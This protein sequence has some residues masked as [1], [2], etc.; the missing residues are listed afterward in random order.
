MHSEGFWS[1]VWLWVDLCAEFCDQVKKTQRKTTQQKKGIIFRSK[2][3]DSEVKVLIQNL[4]YQPASRWRLLLKSLSLASSDPL[5]LHLSK[6]PGCKL[7]SCSYLHL[8]PTGREANNKVDKNLLAI[9]NLSTLKIKSGNRW[10]CWSVWFFRCVEFSKQ[11][12]RKGL[13]NITLFMCGLV[14][15]SFSFQQP[16]RCYFL[17]SKAGPAALKRKKA[18]KAEMAFQFTLKGWHHWHHSPEILQ[19]TF[20]CCTNLDIFTS[21]LEIYS[22]EWLM[23][24]G[25]YPE[26]LQSTFKCF[27]SL[28]I[29]TFIL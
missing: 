2:S 24:G 15:T 28:D 29:F 11:T 19:L 27:T 25:R 14:T 26:I 12:N 21:V 18:F 7:P 3:S 10:C 8:P 23:G 4:S 1:C 9:A 20:K 17:F 22:S 5:G 16:K 13:N 6:A